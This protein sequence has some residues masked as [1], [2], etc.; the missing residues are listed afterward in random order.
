MRSLPPDDSLTPAW[1]D[2]EGEPADE[3]LA[4]LDA[5][6]LVAEA[7]IDEVAYERLMTPPLETDED[8]PV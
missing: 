6:A 5:E 2:G 3:E 4:R 1:E 8:L 7:L